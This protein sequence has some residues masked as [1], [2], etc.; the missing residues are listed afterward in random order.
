MSVV[1]N[2][3]VEDEIPIKDTLETIITFTFLVDESFIAT[4]NFTYISVAKDYIEVIQDG[5]AINVDAVTSVTIMQLVVD[6]F[7]NTDSPLPGRCM[8]ALVDETL[9]IHIAGD[10]KG[11][12]A[13]AVMEALGLL[14][15]TLF[16]EEPY[17]IVSLD[18]EELLPAIHSLPFFNS[19][20]EFEGE[21]YG[22]NKEG[23]FRLAGNT[24]DGKTIHTG[25]V[26]N[27]TNLGFPH[28]KRIKTAIVDGLID[29]TVM[30]VQTASGSA[31]C[32][33]R[34]NKIPVG[35]KF[36][37]RDWEIRL[38]EFERLESFA[39]I[40]VLLRR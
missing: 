14:T 37:G 29:K 4:D 26:W 21:I 3:I 19:L 40:P 1:F 28:N 25:V 33:L 27:K 13:A 38:A 11:V 39:L 24:D 20:I 22:S 36:Y 15:D 31:L 8:T 16:N 23:L 2:L 12:F 5:F 32:V 7:T 30:Q 34:K 10:I 35:R 9:E 6:S 18:T 17:L